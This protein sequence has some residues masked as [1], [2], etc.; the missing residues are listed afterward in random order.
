MWRRE[1]DHQC[2]HHGGQSWAKV[3]SGAQIFCQ[4]GVTHKEGVMQR[5]VAGVEVGVGGMGEGRG[6]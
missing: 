5:L 1:T 4:G 2:P 3:G 6:R